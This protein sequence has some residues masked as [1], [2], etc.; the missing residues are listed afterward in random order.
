MFASAMQNITTDHNRL[1]EIMRHLLS[2]A[3]KFTSQGII[4]VGYDQPQ[5]GRMRIWV[6]DTGK[7]IA[8]EN[9]EHVFERFFKVDEFI[10]GAG[11]GLSV[12]RTL[13]QSLG[14]EVSLESRLGEGSEFSVVIPIQ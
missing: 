7:G 2:N 6:R 5:S 4:I 10:P 14:G 3:T 9:H 1:Q 11:L 13:A 12:C 8:E